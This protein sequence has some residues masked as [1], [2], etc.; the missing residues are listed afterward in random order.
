MAERWGWLAVE[1]NL[2]G[3]GRNESENAAQERGFSSSGRGDNESG[4][5][6]IANDASIPDL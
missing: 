2:T 5:T 1:E 4:G 6:L 3:V